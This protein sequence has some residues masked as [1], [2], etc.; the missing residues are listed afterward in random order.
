MGRQAALARPVGYRC[1]A[2]EIPDALERLLTHYL[3]LR[4]TQEDLQGFFRRHSNDEL[5]GWL[6]GKTIDP[7]ERDQP[8]GRVAVGVGE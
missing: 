7:V 2:S 3:V 8:Q 5:R 1:P 4:N 6:A